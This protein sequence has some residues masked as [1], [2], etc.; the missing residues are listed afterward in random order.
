MAEIEGRF[1]GGTWLNRFCQRLQKVLRTCTGAAR[2]HGK[3]TVLLGFVAWLLFR[4]DVAEG[5]V[6]EYLYIMYSDELACEK[7]KRAKQY[8]QVNPYFSHIKDLKPTA[9]TLMEYY[10]NGH[11]FSLKPA[12]VMSFARGKH[13]DGVICDDIL[14]DPT[15]KLEVLQIEKITQ[16]FQAVITSLPKEG[17]FLHVSGTSQDKTDIFH[18]LEKLPGW[19]WEWNTAFP[20][21]RKKPPLWPEMFTAER[22]RDIEINETGKK[23]FKKEYMLE[24]VRSLDSYIEEH[25]YDMAVDIQLI[26]FGI[27]SKSKEDYEFEETVGGLDIGKH[28]HPS[29]L[30]VFEVVMQK[31]VEY[32]VQVHSCWF[33]HVDYTDQVEHCDQA[34]QRFGMVALFY[35]N[36]RGEFEGFD[37]K[38]ELPAEMQGVKASGGMNVHLAI[39]TEKMFGQ[40]RIFLLNDG[41][42]KRQTLSVDN[43]LKAPESEDGHGD[44]FWS[45]AHAVNAYQEG[46]NPLLTT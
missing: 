25:D 9:D 39:E 14:R 46:R 16:I 30:A 44:S 27:I 26:N 21:G 18:K 35:D 24:D 42:Q 10:V 11:V 34:I 36:T 15:Q 29:H 2:K 37:E 40:K 19:D 6:V 20:D 41:R 7:V 23:N 38:G 3:T 4:C 45:I 32:L 31:N 12:G 22:L 43:N 28:R 5:K 17:G 1:V 33:D 8:I 13:P